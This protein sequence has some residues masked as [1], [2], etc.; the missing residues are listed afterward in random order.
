MP[1][2]RILHQTWGDKPIPEKCQRGQESAKRYHPEFEYRLYNDADM[3]RIVRE[4]LPGHYEAF[5]LLPRL[6][7]QIDMFRYILMYLY[8]GLYADMDYLFFRAFDPLEESVVLT[9]NREDS[10]GNSI[11]ASEAG[12]PFWKGLVDSLHTID[13]SKVHFTVDDDIITDP[14]SCGNAFL[15][16]AWKTWN[17]CPPE[18]C[19]LLPAAS[20]RLFHPEYNPSPA[21]QECLQN[22]GVYGMHLC[23]ESWREG[24]L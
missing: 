8:G 18:G 10:L 7:M 21:H 17:E 22:Q 2:P 9:M 6:I 15:T 20:R 12:Y 24:N 5:C 19:T 11:F 3:F 1:I 16:Q 4:E 23:S 13:R 14:L